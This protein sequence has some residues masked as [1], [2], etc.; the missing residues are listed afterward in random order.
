MDSLDQNKVSA[1]EQSAINEEQNTSV[2]ET[3]AVETQTSEEVAD[4]AAPAAEQPIAEEKKEETPVAD[5]QLEEVSQEEETPAPA[6]EVKEEPIADEQPEEV[7]AQEAEEPVAEQV[8]PTPE[9]EAQEEPIADE[10]TEVVAQEEEVPVEEQ[11][12]VQPELE[13][14]EEVIAATEE[15]AETAPE[16]TELEVAGSEEEAVESPLQLLAA[17]SRA[18]LVAKLKEVVENNDNKNQ[19]AEIDA[20]K[21]AFYKKQRQEKEAASQAKLA[22][23]EGEEPVAQTEEAAEEDVYET[24]LKALIADYREKRD[25]ANAEVEAEKLKNQAKR[26]AIIEKLKEFVASPDTIHENIAA[27]RQLQ[28]EWREI[29]PVPPTVSA[30]LFKTYNLYVEN[31]Y[32]LLKINNEL[33]DYD[34]KKNLEKKTS[35]LDSAKNLAHEVEGNVVGA[36]RRLQ[37]LHEEWA[38]IGPVAKDLREEL[39]ANFKEA[40]GVINKKHQEFFENI[41]GQESGNLELKERLCKLVEEIDFETLKTFKD[42]EE[43]TQEVIG[44][45]QEWKGIGFASRKMNITVYERFRAACDNFFEK[46]NEF[47][48]EIKGELDKNLERKKSL[49]SRVENLKESTE[50]KEATQK[51][52]DA[53]R[54]WKEIGAVSRKYSDAVWKQFIAACDYF[55]EQKDKAFASIRA[56]EKEN[57]A[58]KIEVIE[59]I[60]TFEPT[61]ANQ[62][63]AVAQLKAWIAEYNAV[64]FVPFKEKEKTFKRFRAACD[65]QFDALHVEAKNRHLSNFS[66]N[67]ENI[68]SKD[69]NQLFKEREKLLRVYE[70]L[71]NEIQTSENNIGFFTQGNSKTAN[72]MLAEM[73]FNIDKLKADRTLLLKKI[74]L[75]EK[76]LE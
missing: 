12:V 49:V 63:E 28:Q 65:K 73:Q 33:R 34:F 47:F 60:E 30:H 17:L 7:I 75:I 27:F 8:E 36:F 9:P 39:W 54:E 46:K 68:A 5:K 59:K 43:K 53:Q 45:Q 3:T 31:F 35:L 18:E 72:P 50:W 67:I 24:E 74:Q 41:K 58:K 51:I 66:A 1:D 69:K 71:G 15:I 2:E 55:F 38:Q 26:E 61:E 44:W 4:Q 6:E 56:E 57:L 37:Q 16:T 20:I 14:Q 52:I 22:A 42:W 23:T 10:Q 70:K 48:K 11:P 40:S 64:G 62:T 29:G 76:Q 21:Q 25:K 13:V 32:D 19:K